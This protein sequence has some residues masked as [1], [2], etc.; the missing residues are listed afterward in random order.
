[1]YIYIYCPNKDPTFK[2]FGNPGEDYLK[3]NPKSL[4]FYFLVIWWSKYIYIYIYTHRLYFLSLGTSYLVVLGFFLGQLLTLVNFTPISGDFTRVLGPPKVA[5]RIRE[6]G[7]L[8]SG[9]SR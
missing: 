4:N 6:M 2:R 5:F 3:G 7:P 9:K 8:V 1:M